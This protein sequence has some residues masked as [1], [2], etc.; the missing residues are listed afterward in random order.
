MATRKLFRWHVH[1]F[2]ASATRAAYAHV[3]LQGE[4]YRWE[5]LARK[6]HL[7][8]ETFRIPLDDPNRAD[9]KD[10]KALVKRAMGMSQNKWNGKP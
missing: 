3:I 1:H 8:S 4:E 7:V 5:G 6:R 10:G 2:P 9:I